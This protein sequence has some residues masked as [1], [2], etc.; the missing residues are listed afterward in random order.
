[1]DTETI[2]V[3][4][5]CD[6]LLKAMHH[7][8]DRQC[9]MSDAEVMATAIVAAL[10]FGGNIELARALLKQQGYMP[11]ML[12]RSR[13]N[14]RLHRVKPLF[15]TLFSVLADNWKA[16]DSESLYAIDTFPVAACDQYRILRVRLYQGEDYRGYTASKRRYFY[17]LR[18]YCEL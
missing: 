3:Y 18:A 4:C 16:L 14:R 8:D 1:M 15:L 5:L 9:P 2:T 11:T 12:S 6:D 17:G 13:L 10:Y 7:G